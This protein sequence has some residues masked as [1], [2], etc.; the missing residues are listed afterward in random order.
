M[1]DSQVFLVAKGIF[2]AYRETKKIVDYIKNPGGPTP[3]DIS[4]R[5]GV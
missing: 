3:V 5:F 4:D 1:T 2:N